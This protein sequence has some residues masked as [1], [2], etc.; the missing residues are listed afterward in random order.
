MRKQGPLA[1]NLLE[2]GAFLKSRKA[3]QE[4]GAQACDL[5]I[6]FAPL[7]SLDRGLGARAER[8]GFTLLAA[9]LTPKSRGR[10]FL[11]S[12]DPLLAPAIDPG[13]LTEPK[14]RARL[15]QAVGRAREIVAASAFAPYRGAAPPDEM[16]DEMEELVV[17]LNHGVGT[18]RMGGEED[19]VVDAVLRVHGVA[20][21]RVADASVMP[22]IPRAHPNAT[23]MAIAEKA[24]RLIQG[25]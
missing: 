12:A 20:R 2:A 18:C 23:V 4:K 19:S 3:A 1:S 13:Y 8:H 9:L 25:A 10:M 14:D 11:T 17:S 5:E 24:A 15:E 6:L 16:R 7:F 22:V 21:L